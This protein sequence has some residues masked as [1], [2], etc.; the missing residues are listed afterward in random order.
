MCFAGLWQVPVDIFLWGRDNSGMLAALDL[1][2]IL[3][4]KSRSPGDY[5]LH[6]PLFFGAVDPPVFLLESVDGQRAADERDGEDDFSDLKNPLRAVHWLAGA[7]DA[8]GASGGDMTPVVV[9]SL[10]DAFRKALD[11]NLTSRERA[12]VWYCLRLL[13]VMPPTEEA[14]RVLGVIFEFFGEDGQILLLASPDK[15]SVSIW[16]GGSAKWPAYEEGLA[17]DLSLGI[18]R[19]AVDLSE[20]VLP[21]LDEVPAPPVA[22]QVCISVL[23][24][25]GIRGVQVPEEE[26]EAKGV[27]ELYNLGV[28]LLDAL[29]GKGDDRVLE[30]LE[31]PPMDLED[32]KWVF[33]GIWPRLGA[34]V[35]DLVFYSIVMGVGVYF[36]LPIV[37]KWG[38]LYAVAA[39]YLVGF[40]MPL[41]GAL[42]E[43]SH[44]CGYR[45]LGKAA[46]S[47]TVVS[48]KTSSGPGFLQ[49]LGR[50]LCK[51][52]LSPLFLYCGFLWAVF[53]R[54]R[55]AW[56]DVLTDTAVV[57]PLDDV[58][59]D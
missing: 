8:V 48:T 41:L 11:C 59:E 4:G 26:V 1:T 50:N 36:L 24:P 29:L 22:G 30:D 13:G 43:S 45:T 39:L 32:P 5:A 10:Q 9:A 18:C 57:A 20:D 37:V 56:H 47:L 52:Y 3:S 27:L 33:G 7:R 40:L 35:L 15:S 2:P 58:P 54:Y 51:F 25:E 42:M 31:F 16:E 38:I 17:A 28:G 34:F 44:S 21:L 12:E 19:K 14:S 46:F 23:T 55:R 6:R 49:A 53:H